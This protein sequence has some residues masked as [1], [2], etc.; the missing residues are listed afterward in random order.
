MKKTKTQIIKEKEEAISSLQDRNN[1]YSNKVWN[2]DK[3]VSELESNV[4]RLTGDNQGM[5]EDI[6]YKTDFIRT[7]L[8]ILTGKSS[9]TSKAEC[10]ADLMREEIELVE[11]AR[12]EEKQFGRRRMSRLTTERGELYGDFG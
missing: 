5:K 9:K 2:L 6:K 10:I 7:V 3:K 8:K 1:E 11:R 4:A 12:A